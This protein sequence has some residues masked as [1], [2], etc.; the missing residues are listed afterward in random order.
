[1]PTPTA[2]RERLDSLSRRWF[3]EIWNQRREQTIDELLD[4]AVIV[5]GLDE[6]GAG[7]I[8]HDG[9]RRFYRQ[10]LAGLPDVRVEVEDVLCDGDQTAVRVRGRATH[11]G[12]GFGVRATGRT[13]T[14][15]GIVWL[16][17]R[18]GTVVEAW[19]EFDAA[20][21]MRQITGA[22]PVTVKATS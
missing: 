10:M 18:N 1:M 13:V 16:R 17:W 11:S 2:D 21:L 20:G 7:A 22:A 19:N 14:L 15:T 8:G 3:D 12:D 6:S 5:H 4:P 9:F